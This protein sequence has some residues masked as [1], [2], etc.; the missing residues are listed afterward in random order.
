M[1]DS[2]GGLF[3]LS[4]QLVVRKKSKREAERVEWPFGR[5]VELVKRGLM[6]QKFPLKV[7][8]KSNSSQ[9]ASPFP[10]ARGRWSFL[11]PIGE[12]R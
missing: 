12:T 9:K 5:R 10:N 2:G 11:G 6:H 8:N 7:Q 4:I 1:I 3:D